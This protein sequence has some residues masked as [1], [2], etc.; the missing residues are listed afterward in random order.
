MEIRLAGNLDHTYLVREYLQHYS[1]DFAEATRYADCNL[2]CDRTLF[3]EED[4]LILGTLSWGAREGIQAGIAQLTGLRI[5]PTRRGQGLGSQLLAAGIA[6]MQSYFTNRSA[7]VRRIYAFAPDDQGAAHHFLTGHGFESVVYLQSWRG[8]EV[9]E[10]LYV[11][12]YA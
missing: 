4:G 2:H 11:Q 6:D 9:G 10:R 5:I 3:L 7:R 8:E 12:H 1:P